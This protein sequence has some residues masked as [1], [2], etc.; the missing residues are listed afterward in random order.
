[1]RSVICLLAL[2]LTHTLAFGQGRTTAAQDKA[3]NVP[4]KTDELG[5]GLQLGSLSGVNLEYWLTQD[6]T[7]NAALTAERG[8]VALNATHVWLFANTF[9]GQFRNFVPFVGAGLLGAWGDR[10][11]YFRRANNENFA[12]ALHVPLGI[13]FLPRLERFGIFAELAPSLEFVPQSFA[14]VTGDVG[15]RFYF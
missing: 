6:R 9:G 5:V 10:S 8:N 7:M 1:M 3:L 14:F 4:D 15:A 2:A 11:D 13:E 12:L